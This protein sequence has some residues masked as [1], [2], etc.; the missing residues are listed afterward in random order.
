MLIL[1]TLTL[2]GCERQQPAQPP[3]AAGQNSQSS[4]TVLADTSGQ[5]RLFAVATPSSQ[6]V[7]NY[8]IVFSRAGNAVAYKAEQNREYYVVNNGSAGKPYQ[9]VSDITFSPDGKRLAYVAQSGGKSRMVLDNKEG[10]DEDALGAPLFS[11]D[12]KHLLY[13]AKSNNKWHLVVD[14]KIGED[15]LTIYDQFFSSDATRIITFEQV[16]SDANSP[17]SL[18]TVRDLKLQ[19]LASKRLMA[20]NRVYSADKSR[21]AAIEDIRDKKRIIEVAFNNIEEVKPGQAYDNISLLSYG[22]DGSTLAYVAEKGGK[23]YLVMNGSEYPLPT[24]EIIEPPVINSAKAEAAVIVAGSDGYDVCF[25]SGS[26]MRKK[27][28]KEAAFL[29]FSKDGNAYAHVVLAGKQ[30]QYVVNGK[31]GPSF[32]K[33]LAPQFTPDGRFA[34]CRVRKDGKRFVVVLDLDGKL[35]RQYPD[36][37][38]VFEPVFNADGKSLGYGAKEGAKLVWK[39]EKLP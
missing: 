17:Y 14:G 24:G 11:Q 27:R 16:D 36:Y 37:E 12:S 20:R 7:A 3:L 39:V 21:M 9:E 34:V 5:H 29:S 15:S 25:V 2:A 13:Y 8:T 32:D 6:G 23:L 10:R 31:P 35:V 30:Q 38:M 28:Y 18:L 26:G 22:G 1:I 33:A 19:K 4:S